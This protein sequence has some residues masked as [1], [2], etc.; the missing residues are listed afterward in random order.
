MS[1]LLL[2]I[3][4]DGDLF[5]LPINSA[6][7][8]TPSPTFNSQQ[9]PHNPK[10]PAS[11]EYSN[12]LIIIHKPQTPRTLPWPD[13]LRKLLIPLRP[14]RLLVARKHTL[15]THANT[16][17]IVHRTPP[18]PQQIQTYDPV[19]VDVG[20]QRD[21]PPFRGIRVLDRD[22]EDFGGL[23]G[24]LVAE[25]HAQSE[26]LVLVDGVL[27]VVDGQ[28]EVPFGHVGRADEGYAGGE[29]V[30]DFLEFL[31][32][33][34]EWCFLGFFWRRLEGGGRRRTFVRRLVLNMVW[35]GWSVG[36]G[37]PGGYL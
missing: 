7:H 31:Q 37:A 27:G 18:A 33:V 8:S 19:G 36:V 16:L 11:Q 1:L 14:L 6:F 10:V 23:D 20:V 9:Q 28:V 4:A 32:G 15:Q 29:G 22:E 2:R 34:C 26:G 5:S 30:V 24:V 13:P 12:L 21:V 35:A 3:D 17:H 25:A